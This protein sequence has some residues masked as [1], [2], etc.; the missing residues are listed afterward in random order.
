[1]EIIF[2]Y[3]KYPYYIH[4][5]IRLIVSIRSFSAFSPTNAAVV[6]QNSIS[7]EFR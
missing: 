7:M 1:M 2:N 5:S 6:R 3:L 4:S